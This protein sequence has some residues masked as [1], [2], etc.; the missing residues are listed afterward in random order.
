MKKMIK[1]VAAT[2]IAFSSLF[3]TGMTFNNDAH[4][5]DTQSVTPWYEYNG[6]AGNNAGFLV[7]QDFVRAVKYNNVTL[8][9]YKLNLG[10]YNVEETSSK[11]DSKYDQQFLFFDKDKRPDGTTIV[12]DE[13]QLTK[14]DV[15]KAYGTNYE[16]T[17]A[18][19]TPD[20]DAYKVNGTYTYNLNGN[21]VSFRITNGNVEVVGLGSTVW[22]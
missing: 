14:K 1:V 5:Q 8:N 6:N 19:H 20:G 12:L 22:V 2:G 18:Y 3:A 10:A 7:D 15:F 11:F 13:G 9:G 17:P 21:N 16:F 4:A